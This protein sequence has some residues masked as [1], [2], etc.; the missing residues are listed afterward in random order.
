NWNRTITLG[1]DASI[2]VNV[3]TDTLAVNAAI[4][5]NGGGFGVS[6]EGPGTLS[7]GGTT[8][9]TYT[10]LTQVDAGTLA[11]NKTAGVDAM[12]GPLTIGD[13]ATATQAL[14][15]WLASN[16]LP[17]NTA[18]TVNNNGTLNLNLKTETL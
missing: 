12:R 10:G 11:L 17:D 14:V 2:G 8:A 18:V 4:V 5:D 13:G 9:N 3:G 16:Q 6:K 15:K 1:S 7:Y